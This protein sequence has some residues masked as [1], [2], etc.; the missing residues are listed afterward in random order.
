MSDCRVFILCRYT[1]FARG[2][3]SLLN[4]A[5]DLEIVGVEYDPDKALEQ[6]RA[7]RPDVLLV[8]VP[9]DPAHRVGEVVS[10]YLDSLGGRIV[11]FSLRDNT[12]EV[13]RRRKFL[14]SGPD[15]LLEA[16]RTA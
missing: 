1:L 16:I 9:D 11:R 12:I 13:L 2:I 4:Q 8:E 6:L 10:T 15:D 14:I 5:P 3:Q 7:L